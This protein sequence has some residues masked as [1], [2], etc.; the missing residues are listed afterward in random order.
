MAVNFPNVMKD[1]ESYRFEL[2]Y[3]IS[4]KKFMEQPY[5]NQTTE[6]KDNERNIESS[7]RGWRHGSSGNYM[8]LSTER[9]EKREG[10]KTE[11]NDALNRI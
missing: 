7:Q 2:S 9:K 4:S 10:K 11:K 3:K 1:K 6:T 5:H 8:T